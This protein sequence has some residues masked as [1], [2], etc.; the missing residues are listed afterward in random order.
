L[1]H[2]SG[3]SEGL[4][5]RTVTVHRILIL[6]SSVLLLAACGGSSA[7]REG[8]RSAAARTVQISEREFSLN[9]STITLPRPGRY[10]LEI[11]NDGE[12]T[13]ALEIE[14]SGGPGEAKTGDI[15][16]GEKDTLRFTF[17]ADGSYEMYCPIDGHEQQGMKGTITV[18]STPG[19]GE[20][21]SGQTTTSGY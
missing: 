10:E 2:G 15:E 5:G 3:E 21:T 18:G 19:S 4:V 11:T 20:T 13:H 8:G 7:T 1:R 6:V 12:I 17:S 9:P 16:P 14:G